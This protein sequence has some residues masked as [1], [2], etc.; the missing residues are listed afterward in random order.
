MPTQVK[1]RIENESKEATGR[2][3]II[4]IANNKG[5]V[6]K[7]TSAVNLAAMW[8]DSG[9]KVALVDNDPQGNVSVYMGMESA[10]A[11]KSMASVYSGKT[12][13]SDIL[14]T[15]DYE[16]AMIKNEVN[17]KQENLHLFP[18]NEELDRVAEELSKEGNLSVLRDHLEDI[19]NDYDI[20]IIDN[21]P[22]LSYLTKSALVAADMVLVPSESKIASTK[23]LTR[24]LMEIIKLDK[25]Y[26]TNTL[27]KGFVNKFNK[28]EE[29]QMNNL[30]DLKEMFE[31][32]LFETAVPTNIHLERAGEMGVPVFFIERMKRTSS[33]GAKSYRKISGDILKAFAQEEE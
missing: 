11:K 17:F 1:E 8:A 6:G 7:T 29:S 16:E 20:I 4:A 30:L 5:G 10:P 21:G 14:Q 28:A 2:A 3:A 31:D 9:L 22:S 27:V 15:L 33:E 12:K 23:G 19:V 18:S 25:K 24:L 32:N 13:M 26:K